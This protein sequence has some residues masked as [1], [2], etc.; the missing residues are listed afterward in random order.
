MH[1]I[2]L[3]EH[4]PEIKKPKILL[5]YSELFMM[6]FLC[7]CTFVPDVIICVVRLPIWGS[8]SECLFIMHED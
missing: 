8:S 2:K 3:S 1:N 7:V 6:L 4:F 5:Y